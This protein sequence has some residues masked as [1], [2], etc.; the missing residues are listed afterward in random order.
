MKIAQKKQLLAE[1]SSMFKKS[2]GGIVFD[3]RGMNVESLTMLRKSLA[4]HN[5]EVH[6]LKNRIAIKAAKGTEF[7]ALKEYF[8]NTRSLVTSQDGDL[9]AVVKAMNE[10]LNQET[11]TVLVA[12]L[13]ME[14]SNCQLLS[15][16][17]IKQLGTLPSKDELIAKLLFLLNAPV[18]QLCRTL[19]EIPQSLARVLQAV[20]DSKP[21]S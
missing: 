7:E 18:I 15:V 13:L 9:V 20:A 6:V 3:H 8:T 19:Q 17:E 14:G 16:E 1:Y 4:S 11:Q 21:K 2:F 10:E 5:S 12:G